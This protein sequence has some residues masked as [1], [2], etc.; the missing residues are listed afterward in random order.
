VRR[1]RARHDHGTDA[2]APGVGYDGMC[3]QCGWTG[4]FESDGTVK[5][6]GHQFPC[7]GCGCMLRMR[8]EAIVILNEFGRGRHLTLQSL[9]ADPAF[10]LLAVYFVGERGATRRH[11]AR[12]PN[13]VDSRYDPD[14]EL[15]TPVGERMTIQDLQALTF[16]DCSFDLVVSSHVM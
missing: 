6:V 16:A 13:Y 7:G 8:D 5:M 1:F 12:V 14:T 2:P 3:T 15:G 9:V 4:R 10:R 11:L